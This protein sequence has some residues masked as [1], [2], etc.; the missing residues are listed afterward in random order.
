MPTRPCKKHINVQLDVVLRKFARSHGLACK[1][2]PDYGETLLEEAQLYITDWTP[3]L[4]PGT[5]HDL[6]S[7]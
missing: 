4:D 2:G 7:R 1:Q 3:L 6:L 5:S